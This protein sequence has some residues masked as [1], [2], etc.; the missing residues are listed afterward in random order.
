MPIPALRAATGSAPPKYQVDEGG[1]GKHADDAQN[2][3]QRGALAG[4][5]SDPGQSVADAGHGISNNGDY[6]P[7]QVAQGK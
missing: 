1:E 5:G 2:D 7:V 3:D 6:R 4:V